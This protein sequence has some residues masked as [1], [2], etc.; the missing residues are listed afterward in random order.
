MGCDQTDQHLDR[1]SRWRGSGPVKDG[2]TDVKD[3]TAEL[4]IL[5]IGKA[6]GVTKHIQVGP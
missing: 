6:D 5:H 4:Y 2:C 3:L 1:Q